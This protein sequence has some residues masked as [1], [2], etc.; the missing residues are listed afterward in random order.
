MG[1]RW[2]WKSSFARRFLADLVVLIAAAVRR[3][4]DKATILVLIPTVVMAFCSS[5]SFP[6]V[7]PGAMNRTLW[8]P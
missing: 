8:V 5:V 7:L 6:N 3:E 2:T 4:K 1:G